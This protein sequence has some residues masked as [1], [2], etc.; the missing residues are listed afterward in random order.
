MKVLLAVVAGILVLVLVG[1]SALLFVGVRSE[2]RV[3]AEA[4][5]APMKLA[6]NDASAAAAARTD[7]VL[8]R[9]DV[10]TRELD[11]LRA[12][13]AALK[14]GSARAPAASPEK[15]EEETAAMFA[16]EHR[17]AI[18]KVI[19][20][21]RAEQERKRTEEQRQRDMENLLA[22][23]ERTAKKFG[24]DATQ[25]KSL[26]DVYVL[27][28]QKLAD[29]RAAMRDQGGWN[30]DP[31]SVRTAMQEFRDWRLNE[32]T[33]RL[34]AELGGRIQ[35]ADVQNFRGAMGGGGG[36]QGA[37][38]GGGRRNRAQAGPNGPQGQNNG[39]PGG[40]N[41]GQNGVGGG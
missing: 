23:A 26:A 35:E 11:D 40:A 34:G 17:D 2:T 24:L 4:P 37:N 21:D 8:Q 41:N 13:L 39:T 36:Q 27:E 28:N 30:G 33:T 22:R 10:V 19:A 9:L 18:M 3:A 7:E 25:Q 5:P 32:L 20:D 38:G 1:V 12:E 14:A 29:M 16:S 15:L 31:E 6:S